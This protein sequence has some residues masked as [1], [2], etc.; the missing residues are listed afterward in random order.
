MTANQ[1]RKTRAMMYTQ[2]LGHLPLK[3][4]DDLYKAALG[5]KPEKVA[6]I[7]HDKD[8]SPNGQPAKEHVHMML[9]WRN[10]RSLASVAKAFGDRPQY[11]QA[12]PNGVENGFAYLTH[13][14]D[15]ARAKYQYPPEAVKANFDYAA[16]LA[17]QTQQ[18]ARAQKHANAQI[19]LNDLAEGR[20]TKAQVEDQLTGADYARLKRQ[21]EDVDALRLRREAKQWREQQWKTGRKVTTLWIWGDSGVGKTRLARDIAGKDGR[22]YFVS[23]S[24]RDPFQNYQGQHSVALDEF[25]PES[26][27]Y[28]DLLKL[29]DPNALANEVMAPSRYNDKAV[30]ADTIIITTPY[31]PIA[32]YRAKA[33]K[34]GLTNADSFAQLQRRLSLV[35]HMTSDK[36][37]VSKYDEATGRYVDDIATAKPNTLSQQSGPEATADPV[38]LYNDILK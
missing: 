22:D 10:A 17:K 25:R 4:P 31:D 14:T 20:L 26:M 18:V 24:T 38:D 23:G 12:W 9:Q 6:M 35:I 30:A 28:Q 1:P 8:I 11:V 33:D 15:N 32:Y 36:T 37:Y 13:R 21:I 16:W 27:P 2:Q 19:L 7:V 5:L 34:D 3:T 29:T